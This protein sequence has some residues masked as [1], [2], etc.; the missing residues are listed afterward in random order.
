MQVRQLECAS[1]CS[2]AFLGGVSRI[3]APGSIGV[4]RTSFAPDSTVGR[5]EAG[6]GVQALTAEIISYLSEM[7]ASSELL[8]FALRYDRTDIRYLSASEMSDLRVTTSQATAGNLPTQNA[9][10]PKIGTEA[11]DSQSIK[12]AAV[13][14]IRNLIERDGNDA[15][16]AIRTLHRAMPMSSR[17]MASRRPLTKCWRTNAAIL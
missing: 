10:T 17:A 15:V 3:A 2:L 16:S 1:A 6:A 9:N 12:E 8:N 11:S 13:G 14:V 4:R 7:G 5:D